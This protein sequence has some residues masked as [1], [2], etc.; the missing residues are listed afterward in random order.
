MA[1][2]LWL[3]VP[4]KQ[5]HQQGPWGLGSVS[6][7]QEGTGSGRNKSFLDKLER[8]AGACDGGPVGACLPA[9]STGA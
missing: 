3:Q 9:Q 7:H 4:G 2:E 5:R 6:N 1:P 8:Q